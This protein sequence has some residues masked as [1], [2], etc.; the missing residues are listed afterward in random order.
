MAGMK[1]LILQANPADQAILRMAHEVREIKER[2]MSA[3]PW[4]FELIPEGAVR[5]SDLQGLLLRHRPDIVHFSG[6]GQK[7][8]RLLFENDIGWSQ[9]IPIRALGCI[10]EALKATIRC[11]VLNACHSRKQAEAIAKSI[12]YVIGMKSSIGNRA[13]I[14]FSGSFYQAIAFGKTIPEAFELAKQEVALVGVPE[15]KG[16]IMHPT[17]AKKEQA[18]IGGLR[19]TL[20]AEFHLTDKGRPCVDGNLY[21]M[22]IFIKNAPADAQCCVYQ[23]IDNWEDSIEES[24]EF[25][26][27]PNDGEGLVSERGFYGNILIRATLWSGNRGM[28]LSC[29]LSEAFRNHYGTKVPRKVR[30]AVKE[31]EEN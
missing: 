14:R 27:I 19:P 2:V 11:V 26:E 17:R 23:Y 21:E 4:G 9:P 5:A 8:G 13:A 15:K 16:P 12:P 25:D 30:K 20:C 10:F 1:I 29:Y 31:I 24:Y 6:H 18:Q 7:R 3:V 28:A 22:K